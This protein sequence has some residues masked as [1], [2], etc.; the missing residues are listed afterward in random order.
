MQL[1]LTFIVLLVNYLQGD[2]LISSPS[3]FSFI[4]T[5]LHSLILSLLHNLET[6]EIKAS[7]I[8]CSVNKLWICIVVTV[9]CIYILIFCWLLSSSGTDKLW[10]CIVVTVF[11]IYILIFCCLLS[12]SGTDILTFNGLQCLRT[13]GN[14]VFR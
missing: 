1:S 11:C 12:S 14:Q 2:M 13:R 4:V 7:F 5:L 10:I 3:L 6:R 8:K 9:F